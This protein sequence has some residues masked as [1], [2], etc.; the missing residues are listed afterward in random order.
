[1]NTVEDFIIDLSANNS[2]DFITRGEVAGILRRVLEEIQMQGS[3]APSA[4]GGED[5]GPPPVAPSA[6]GQDG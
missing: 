1:M 4:K 3:V 5:F 2:G 6:K